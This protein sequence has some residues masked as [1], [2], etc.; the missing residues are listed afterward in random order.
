MALWMNVIM[1]LLM[2][3]IGTSRFIFRDVTKATVYTR[4][5]FRFRR[6]VS[7]R[8]SPALPDYSSPPKK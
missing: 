5:L 8:P 6:R 7:T 2:R 1:A 4:R 3:P